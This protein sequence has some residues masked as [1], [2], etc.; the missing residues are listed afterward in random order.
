MG[1]ELVVIGARAAIV[2]GGCCGS[3]DDG[4]CRSHR[5]RNECSTFRGECGRRDPEGA[6]R[7]EL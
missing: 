7:R 6:A 5:L 4:C 1:E 2:F 3:L